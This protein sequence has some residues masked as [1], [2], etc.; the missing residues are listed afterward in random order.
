MSIAVSAGVTFVLDFLLD[1]LLVLVPANPIHFMLQMPFF[2][3]LNIPRS[4]HAF[5]GA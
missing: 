2:I 4:L 1:H 5:E 3:M